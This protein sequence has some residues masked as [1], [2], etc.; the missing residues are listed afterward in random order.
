MNNNNLFER[1][2][3]SFTSRSPTITSVWIKKSCG[4]FFS[5][6]Q[7]QTEIETHKMVNG[8]WICVNI[9][10]EKKTRDKRK[11]KT[12]ILE[13]LFNCSDTRTDQG[14][15][16]YVY[17]MFVRF[18]N[19]IFFSFC[20]ILSSL[21]SPFSLFLQFHAKKHQKINPHIDNRQSSRGRNRSLN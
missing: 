5:S 2:K 10:F 21:S 17:L 15:Y 19:H 18:F 12:Q 1:K 8:V 13:T 9:K 4:G 14:L 20:L 6:S 16:V 11:R 7:A 3:Q